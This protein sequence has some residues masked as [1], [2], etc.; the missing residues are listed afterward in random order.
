M[1]VDPSHFSINQLHPW[2]KC[3]KILYWGCLIQMVNLFLITGLS[4]IRNLKISKVIL[5]GFSMGGHVA[6]HSVFRNNVQ[7][8][9]CFA[10]SSFLINQS[11][12]YKSLSNN[13]L[14]QIPLF[15][16]HGDCDKIVPYQW[17]QTTHRK[18]LDLNIKSKFLL[19]K[20]LDHEIR[21][22][23]VHDVFRWI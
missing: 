21:E 23:E 17:A 20:K 10:M 1:K 8:D 13:N 12:V 11:E 14:C 19:Y 4:E 5:G 3:L 16:A 2:D 15:I 6:I 7:V 18:L 9:K 22:D